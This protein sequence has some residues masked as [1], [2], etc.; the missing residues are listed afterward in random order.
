VSL[1]HPLDAT[2]RL[3]LQ[4]DAPPKFDTAWQKARG[5]AEYAGSQSSSQQ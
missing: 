2:R 3:E 1:A 5:G 4:M